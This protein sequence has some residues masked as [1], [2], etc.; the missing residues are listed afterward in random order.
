MTTRQHAGVSSLS[1]VTIL[2][3]SC[4]KREEGPTKP[5]FSRNSLTILVEAVNRGL[6]LLF[7]GNLLHEFVCLFVVARLIHWNSESKIKWWNLSAAI[8]P[9]IVLGEK[10]SINQKSYNC[11]YDK[12]K[13]HKLKNRNGTVLLM[14]VKH[15]L[16]AAAPT[17]A[18]GKCHMTSFGCLTPWKCNR[19]G[20]WNQLQPKLD[21]LGMVSVHGKWFT[22]CGEAEEGGRRGGGGS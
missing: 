10:M 15:S 9:S 3:L 1:A 17:L 13:F 14:W 6:S 12:Y 5:Q 20:N 7:S 4:S 16:N 8:A 11:L 19:A 2:F 18:E 21:T 22:G